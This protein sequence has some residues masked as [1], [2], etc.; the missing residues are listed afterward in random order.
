[1]IFVLSIV[2]NRRTPPIELWN[3]LRLSFLLEISINPSSTEF[4]PII[5]TTVESRSH[6]LNKLKVHQSGIEMLNAYFTD[7]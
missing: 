2:K 3:W 7:Y 5:S 6:A 4:A 1:M